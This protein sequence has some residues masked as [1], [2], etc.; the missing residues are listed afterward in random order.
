MC[1]SK[2]YTQL[3]MIQTRV[4]IGAGSAGIAD[5]ILVSSGINV[6][7]QP[8]R[9]RYGVSYLTNIGAMREAEGER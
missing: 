3:N 1:L 8:R 6:I 7:A 4:R 2:L 5:V 9:Q